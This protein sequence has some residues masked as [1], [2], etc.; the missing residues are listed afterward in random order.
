MGD[1]EGKNCNANNGQCIGQ[2][3]A[4]M[5]LKDVKCL[6]P[7]MTDVDVLSFFM[8]FERVLILNEVDCVH[9][10]KLLRGPRYSSPWTVSWASAETL[11]LPTKAIPQP[12]Q[13]LSQPLQPASYSA[14]LIRLC[15]AL[16]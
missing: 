11:G 9:W 7:S 14:D 1:R 12:H 8:S 4:A 2:R 6:L 13:H 3:S 5:D 16:H 10:S 15:T